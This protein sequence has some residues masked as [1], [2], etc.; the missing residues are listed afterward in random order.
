MKNLPKIVLI[1]AG[2]V[3]THLSQA[4]YENGIQV[5]QIFSRNLQK[6][7][8]LALQINAKPTNDLSKITDKGTI[9]I[10]AV[11]DDA[12]REVAEQL[13][14][15]KGEKRLF[16]HTSGATPSTVFKGVFKNY[17]VFYPL[18]TFSIDRKANFQNIPICTHTKKKNRIKILEELA[19]RISPKTYKIND[20]QRA[21]LHVAAV[22]VNNFSNHLFHI[23]EQICE[24]GNVDFDIL[25][26]LIQETTAKVQ[27]NRPI[28]MQTGPAKRGDVKT[29]QRHL[30][31]LK[32]QSHFKD[33]YELLTANISKTYQ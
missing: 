3:A 13:A 12:I 28:E 16:V 21:T 27:S 4:L 1:G 23:G 18:Q 15:L 10:I 29:I 11:H 2:N 20:Q 14:Y 6:A 22:F 8:E 32:D 9:Y 26:P 25:R 33:I 19:Q 17:G 31:Y 24:D 7:T 30:D 5:L